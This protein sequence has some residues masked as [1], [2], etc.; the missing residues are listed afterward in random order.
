MAL[1]NDRYKLWKIA[2]VL[3]TLEAVGLL[4]EAD[5]LSSQ[6]LRWWPD[7]PG[8]IVNRVVGLT[9]RGDLAAIDRLDTQL[10]PKTFPQWMTVPKGLT[11]A[12]AGRDRARVRRDC[13]GPD[14]DLMQPVYCMLVLAQIGRSRRSLCTRQSSLSALARPQRRGGG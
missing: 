10:G 12:A 1:A 3:R 4:A 9:E 6:A 5:R 7:H 13:A 8:L 11:A 2:R 14:P